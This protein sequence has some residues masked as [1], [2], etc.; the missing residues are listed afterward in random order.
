MRLPHHSLT[1]NHDTTASTGT[2][3]TAADLLLTRPQE[4]P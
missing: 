4:I 3:A 2:L 1:L